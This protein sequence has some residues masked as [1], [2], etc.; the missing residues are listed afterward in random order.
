MY[1]SYSSDL[2]LYIWSSQSFG[3]ETLNLQVRRY[4]FW[5]NT[6][7]P[8]PLRCHVAKKVLLDVKNL[9]QK[10]DLPLLG[11]EPQKTSNS[12]LVSV[13]G[14]FVGFFWFSFLYDINRQSFKLVQIWVVFYL[15]VKN[16]TLNNTVFQEILGPSWLHCICMCCTL[17]ASSE[18]LLL[19]CACS[20]AEEVCLPLST[21]AFNVSFKDF[22]AK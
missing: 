19:Q 17:A 6:L 4:M 20:K 14:M 5:D 10:E 1:G 8:F 2:C 12:K 15:P 7:L 13:S 16:R 18:Q 9:F 11:S 3:R 22:S 21:E